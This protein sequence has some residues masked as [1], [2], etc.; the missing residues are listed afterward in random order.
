VL[1]L[2]HEVQSTVQDTAWPQERPAAF[3]Y[4]AAGPNGKPWD[5]A[6]DWIPPLVLPPRPSDIALVACFFGSDP[7]RIAAARRGAA[8][9]SALPGAETM[10]LVEAVPEAGETAIPEWTGERLEVVVGSDQEGIW[11]KE[12]MLELGLR[13]VFA[14][15]PKAVLC[16]LD[17]Y[18]GVPWQAEWLASASAALDRGPVVQPWALVRDTRVPADCYRSYAWAAAAGAA[19]IR[20]GQG[21]CVALKREFWRE[22]AGLPTR[23]LCG[24]GD[25]EAIFRWAEPMR[26]E[27]AFL[28]DWRWWRAQVAEYT[29]PVCAWGWL[30]AEMVHEFHGPRNES[31]GRFYHRRCWIGE[32][33]GGWGELVELAGNGLWRWRSTVAGA[34]GRRMEARLGEVQTEA[35]A[36]RVWAECLAAGEVT[37][38]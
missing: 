16:D 30:P 17:T 3:L 1:P 18:P 2:A 19:E 4:C 26:H 7:R 37:A 32:L 31:G 27:T 23:C 11:Q 10:L 24:C 33:A 28:R 8:V 29:G 9:L 6:R 25:V 13:Q 12:A 36:R 38:P 35:D 34:A 22:A 14:T 21:F 5:I 15:V 20:N